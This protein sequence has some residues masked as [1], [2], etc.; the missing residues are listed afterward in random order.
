MYTY[1]PDAGFPRS[2]LCFKNRK[3]GKPFSEWVDL[4]QVPGYTHFKASPSC[5]SNNI[6]MF[7]TY[8]STSYAEMLCIRRLLQVSGKRQ[9]FTRS[10]STAKKVFF[11]LWWCIS[12]GNF[13]HASIK[14]SHGP[15]LLLKRCFVSLWWCISVGNFQHMSIKLSHGP[16]LLLKGCFVSLWWCIS[17]GNFQH[18]STR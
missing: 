17:V 8:I 10:Y 15:I 9:A 16:I 6:T 3:H 1:I 2:H 5:M 14:L 11:S 13:Q 4:V 12:V 7:P 18:V